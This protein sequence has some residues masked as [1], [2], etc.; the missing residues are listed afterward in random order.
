MA[1]IALI[2]VGRD[3]GEQV[4]YLA[5]VAALSHNDGLIQAVASTKLLLVLNTITGHYHHYVT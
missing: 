1:A 4:Q 5:W 2:V 3:R